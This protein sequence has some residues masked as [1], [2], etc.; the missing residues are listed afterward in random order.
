MGLFSPPPPSQPS[1]GQP[2]YSNV[3]QVPLLPD[4]VNGP[5]VGDMYQTNWSQQERANQIAR[6]QALSA[7]MRLRASQTSQGR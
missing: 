4:L 6:D 3:Q 1:G 2:P 7:E 5:S